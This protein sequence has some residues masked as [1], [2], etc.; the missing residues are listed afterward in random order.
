MRR[1][2]VGGLAALSALTVAAAAA[3]W[4]RCP[5]AALYHIPCPG[6]GMTRALV[7]LA[8]GHVEASLQ[9]NALAVPSLV[10]GALVAVAVL[11]PASRAGA[12]RRLTRVAIT[13][14]IVVYAAALLLWGLR[15]FG[16]FGGPVPV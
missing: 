2:E 8:R 9:M 14:G 13:S 10:V 11:Q 3:G 1:Q 15:W 5:L 16:L 4:L 12:G 7:L 6:C